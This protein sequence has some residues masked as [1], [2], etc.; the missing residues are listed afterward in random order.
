MNKTMKAIIFQLILLLFSQSCLADGY[1][2]YR[3][4]IDNYPSFTFEQRQL[5]ITELEKSKQQDVEKY[6]ILGMLYF[7][8]SIDVMQ[9]AAQSK[10]E[11][12]KIEDVV[13]EE[14]VS[15]Y[16][17]KTEENYNRV[18]IEHPG[19]KF[20]YCKYAELYWYSINAKGLE[21]I[22]KEVGGA[23]NNEQMDQCKS[24]LEDVAEK[25]A[26]KGYAAIS[27]TIYKTAVSNWSSYPKYMLEAIG[28]I[29]NISNNINEAVVW[30]KRC[31]SEATGDRKKRCTSKYSAL[32]K[33]PK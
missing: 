11:K 20:I 21:R 9:K 13:S 15:I 8:Q 24:V 12:P 7:I 23:G 30:W 4:I 3:N 6:Y 17:N 5:S 28:D 18:N 25:L 10:S 26:S 1:D 31:A 22:T 16:L 19:Y 14:S 32:N 2:E 29:E 33:A 27:K